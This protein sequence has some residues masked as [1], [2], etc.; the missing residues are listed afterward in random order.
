VRES[1]GQ[2]Q[3]EYFEFGPFQLDAGKKAL[4]RGAEFVPLTPKAIETL[5]VLV[6]DAGHVVTRDQLLERVWPDA[7][8]EEGSITNNISALRKALNPYFGGEE[9][10]IATVTRRGYRFTAPV[11]LRSENADIALASASS[12]SI[13]WPVETPAADAAR[14]TPVS[15]SVAP[16]PPA[17]AGWPWRRYAAIVAA[18]VV[19]GAMAAFA[20][21][22]VRTRSMPAAPRR[23]IA[24][25]A[26]K[27]LSGQAEHA[28]LSTALTETIGAELTAGG[29]LRLVSAENVTRMQQE[30]AP[31]AGIGLTRK[32]LDEIGRDLGCDWILTGDYLVVGTK[33]RVDV[34]LD[35][36]TTGESIATASVTDEQQA[37]LTLV[38]RAGSDLR[39]RLNVPVPGTGDLDAARAGF[40]SSPDATRVYFLGLDALRLR[41]GPKAAALL[42]QAVTADPDFAL[43]HSALANTW[44][45]LGYNSRAAAE[46]KRAF[47]LSQKLSPEDRLS[48]EAQ[49]LEAS[50]NWSKA[51]EKYRQLW[52]Q[53]P[54]N[55]EYGL[56]LANA[57][58]LAGESKH[59]QDIID[60]MRRMS[61][62]DGADPRIDLIQ[63]TV[64]ERAG[65]SRLALAA[66]T[67]AAEKAQAE[68]ATV[69]L[70]RARIKEGTHLNRLNRTDEALE[71]LDE[72]R[73]LFDAV[74]DKGGVADALRW[75]G[76]ILIDRGQLEAAEAKLQEALA[77]AAPMHYVRLTSEILH[78]QS[79]A[80]RQRGLLTK[81]RTAAEGALAAAREAD[82]QSSI[83]RALA[84]LAVVIKLQGDYARAL[85]VYAEA[86]DVLHKIGAEPDANSVSNNIGAM[87]IGLGHLAGLREQ[88]ETLLAAEQ[89]RGVKIRIGVRLLNLSMIRTLQ[90][91]LAKA[92]TLTTDECRAFDAIGAKPYVAA[93]RIRLGLLQKEL[94]RDDD[95]RTTL[96]S[97][98]EADAKRSPQPPVDLARLA[99][100]QLLFGDRPR[101]A[102]TLADADTQLAGREYIPEQAIPVGIAKARL[103]AA[104]DRPSAAAEHFRKAKSDAERYGFQPLVFE[105]RLALAELAEPAGKRTM[106]TQ[107]SADAKQAG[108]DVFALRVSRLR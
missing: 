75:S 17:R 92:E 11:R 36:V 90:G 30:L 5:I 72:A 98:S 31:P 28:W 107:I 45:L 87:D 91:D 58:F 88:F 26:M 47:D 33:I 85:T 57:S 14:V 84:E 13:A 53:Y 48:V 2:Q 23:S 37:L 54:D 70:A 1:P 21:V 62:P 8:V 61:P 66:A 101:A 63:T 51:A 74:G 22:A 76:G 32:Q 56:K 60:E 104:T 18:V 49:W 40:P 19:V 39:S 43:A 68:K 16:P 105:S 52:R 12:A 10:P 83:G 38:G 94:G 73:R 6:E 64:A 59:A 55:I 25:L 86:E 44:L 20:R 7:F 65:D 108:L 42:Q 106:L 93:C 69:L 27:N 24:V 95:A 34:R 97:I 96:A 46:A 41:D 89:K 103:E 81:A 71:H 79:G 78:I 77:I 3:S 99:T 4:Y 35:D 9:G 102:A 15:D 82:D 100:L 29:R 80:A 50:F 67:R